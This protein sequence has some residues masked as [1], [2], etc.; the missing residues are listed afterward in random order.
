MVVQGHTGAVQQCRFGGLTSRLDLVLLNPC[1]PVSNDV[2]GKKREVQ[3]K[4]GRHGQDDGKERGSQII[5]VVEPQVVPQR[6]QHKLG[7]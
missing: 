2:A 5:S 3:D 7:S 1:P 6:L 4:V